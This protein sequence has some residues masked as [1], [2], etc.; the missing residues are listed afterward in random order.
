M[1]LRDVLGKD[2]EDVLW[3]IGKRY[4]M[5]MD[6]P[7]VSNSSTVFSNNEVCHCGKQIYAHGECKTHYMGH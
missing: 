7:A 2:A 5:K 4:G 1:T 3:G 6:P